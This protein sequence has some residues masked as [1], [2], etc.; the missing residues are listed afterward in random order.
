MRVLTLS[1]DL[2]NEHCNKL[3]AMARPFAPDLIVTIA[4]G[5][6]FVGEK[7]FREVKH[8]SIYQQRPST[9]KK[10]RAEY[11]WSIIRALPMWT[12]NALRIIEA[13]L[14]S[15][16]K[17]RTYAITINEDLQR[18]IKSA[19][20]ILIIDDAVDSGTTLA[21]IANAI[22]AIDGKR[23]IATAAITVTTR[24]PAIQPDFSLYNN[25][26]LIRFP[27]SSDYTTK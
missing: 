5:G 20:R 1:P 27:W 23:T 10:K 13:N 4:R 24:H 19:Q 9:Q 2:F 18:V 6:D 22:H 12:R 15:L 8:I 26:S 3:E 14:L 16:K 7:I 25:G 17:K 11:A 21:S